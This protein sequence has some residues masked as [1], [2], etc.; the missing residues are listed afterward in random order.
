VTQLLD[1]LRAGFAGQYEIERELMGGGMSRLFLAT[2]RA[3]GR[4]VVIKILPPDWTGEVSAARFKRESALTARLQHPN[5]LPIL[6][7]GE[8]GGVLFYVMPFV[9]GESLRAR[10]EREGALPVVDALRLLVEV[11]DALACAHA[12]GIIHRDIKPE[13]ILLQRG[14]ALL[15]DFG[16]AAALAAS[17]GGAPGERLT[18]T[19]MS[20]GTLGYMAPEQA[21]AERHIDGRADVYS[22]GIVGYEMLAGRPPFTGDN[23]QALLVAHLTE[24]AQPLDDVRDEVPPTVA[25]VIAHAMGKEPESRYASAT[26]LRDALQGA[27]T[28]VMTSTYVVPRRPI[29]KRVTRAVRQLTTTT[30]RTIGPE[31]PVKRRITVL[32]GAAIAV[33]AA[34]GGYLAW[35]G[36]RAFRPE[37]P[38]TIAV[39]PFTVIESTGSSSELAV[40]GEGM[41]DILRRNLDG[42]GPLRVSPASVALKAW[43][44]RA[45]PGGLDVAADDLARAAKARYVVY[46]KL[47]GIGSAVRLEARVRDTKTRQ[48]VVADTQWT[49]PRVEALADSLSNMLVAD[50][51]RRHRVGAV[52]NASWSASTNALALRS[53][54]QGEQHYRR[55]AWDS[56]LA[57]YRESARL[58]SAF[59][60]PLHRIAQMQ[61]W[62]IDGSAK[63]S[64]DAALAAGRTAARLPERDRLLVTAD[65][66]S[67]AITRASFTGPRDPAQLR[68][69]FALLDT[70][71]RRYPGDPEASYALA[72]ARYHHGYGR[73]TDMTERAVLDAF[74]RAIGL[75]S[76]FAPSYVHAVELALTLDGASRAR[77]YTTPYLALRPSDAE[78]DAVRIIDALTD[79]RRG[80]PEVS[81]AVLDSMPVRSLWHAWL[82]TKRWSDSAQSA[83]RVLR[84]WEKRLDP[85]AATFQSDSNALSSY[86]PQ[87]LAYRGRLA[88]AYQY[89]GDGPYRLFVELALL[90]ALPPARVDSVTA[91]WLGDPKRAGVARH[92]L[93]WW[94]QRGD[95][96]ALRRFGERA[97]ATHG[98]TAVRARRWLAYDTTALAAYRALMRRD[99]VAAL[100]RFAALSDTLCEGC[101]LDRLNEAR[102]LKGQGRAGLA[103]ADTV[104]RQRLFTTLTLTE[105]LLSVERAE[106]ASQLGNAGEARRSAASV[107]AAWAAGEPPVQPYVQRARRVLA[108]LGSPKR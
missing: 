34:I 9:S 66:V 88:E 49:A 35:Q 101:F 82:A 57:A 46:G 76:A 62:T 25:E 50:M 41:I 92:A 28:S 54:L 30:W 78:A 105:H 53:F 61:D 63:A 65:S 20:L 70:V 13:N 11:A 72:E 95:T 12:D 23:A 22:L 56:A 48:W 60:L 42:A 43:K 69:L 52:K 7:A 29:G 14:H 19:G 68:R 21:V 97:L 64:V 77:A 90:G 36:W 2:E 83:Y 31:A 91:A 106:V 80:A 98:D 45:G 39:A 40:W 51:E 79:P 33:G 103:R 85:R 100:Q 38:V 74:D 6:S 32:G 27:L 10:L 67:A 87:Q 99:T 37:E 47:I 94:A 18:R 8:Q 96:A 1:E 81:A 44:P 102:L 71:V 104:L 16:I 107:V 108:T 3:L 15:A 5:I 4:Q 75:D 59:A 58:D 93:S 24:D 55:A 89:T 86:L 73:A 17:D 26:E 84:A